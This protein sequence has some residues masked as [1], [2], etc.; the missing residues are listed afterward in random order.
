[1]KRVIAY[2]DGFSMY[3]AL[4]DLKENHLKWLDLWSLISSLLKEDEQLEKVAYFSAFA[5]W[6]PNSVVRHKTYVE[7][8]E[9]SGVTPIMSHFKQKNRSCK[10]CKSEWLDHEEKETD[11]R[12]ALG[13][14]Q[15]AFEDTYDKAFILTSDSDLVPA[16]RAVK[17][18][19]PDKS[20][21]VVTPPK[22]HHLSRDLR[23]QASSYALTKGRIKK[24]LFP[25]EISTQTNRIIQRPAEYDPPSTELPVE[26]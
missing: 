9:N 11:V 15:G 25:E 1:M 14:L 20:L 13:I 8:L 26:E 12:I 4:D 24:H 19:C 5:T 23:A 6:R 16:I 18:I 10:N 21:L 7:A 2:I 22:R 3:H 17:E